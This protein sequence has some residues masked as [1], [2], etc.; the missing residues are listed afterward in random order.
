[1]PGQGARVLPVEVVPSARARCPG[2]TCGGSAQ[3]PGTGTE[4]DLGLTMMPF[5]G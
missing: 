2:A 4:S 5:L 3:C 1:M